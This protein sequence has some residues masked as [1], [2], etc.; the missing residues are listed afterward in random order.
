MSIGDYKKGELKISAEFFPPKDYDRFFQQFDL[1]KDLSLHF[2]SITSHAK[3]CLI[4]PFL[5]ATIREEYN[6]S[7]FAHITCRYKNSEQIN[8][9]LSLHDLLGNN[10]LVA[11]LGDIVNDESLQQK[12]RH[13]DELVK[14]I[15]ETSDEKTIAVAGY[16]EGYKGGTPEEDIFWLKN[17]LDLGA[18]MVLLQMCFDSKIYGNYLRLAQEVGIN[19]PIIPGIL[20]LISKKM[21]DKILNED[22]FGHPTIPQEYVDRLRSAE[23]V[24]SEGIQIAIE[25]ILE[26]REVGAQGVHLY[27]MNSGRIIKEIV[28]GLPR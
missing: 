13:A 1:I 8:K 17:K 5:A 10:N 23:D 16:P 12:C 26:M 4:T 6:F 11:L 7:T 9:E 22:R 19:K 14:Q 25:I 2:V 18:D 28:E 21:L 15:R 24:R 20:P 27:G 3:N